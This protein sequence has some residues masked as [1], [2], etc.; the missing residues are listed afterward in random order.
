MPEVRLV[1]GEL[2]EASNVEGPK[3][4]RRFSW[5]VCVCVCVGGWVGVGVGVGRM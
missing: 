4:T 3:V 2:T 1:G 5:C